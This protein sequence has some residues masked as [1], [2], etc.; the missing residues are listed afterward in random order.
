MDRCGEISSIK[1]RRGRHRA[2]CR[3]HGTISRNG[4]CS[5]AV[6]VPVVVTLARLI[7]AAV[8]VLVFAVPILGRAGVGA[9]PA[10]VAVALRFGVAVAVVVGGVATVAELV[11]AVLGGASLIDAAVAVVVL[12]VLPLVV[13]AGVG[14]LPAVVAVALRDRPPVAVGVG[15]GGTVIVII[16]LPVVVLGGVV[17]VLVG[18]AVVGIGP[19]LNAAREEHGGSR[20]R[21]RQEAHD[22]AIVRGWRDA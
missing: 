21:N 13:V 11:P 10:V 6:L 5:V 8:A 3:P 4:S 1:R 9:V 15:G 17:A 14:A 2:R 22:E 12:V 7:D 19:L 16:V 18:T 20:Q